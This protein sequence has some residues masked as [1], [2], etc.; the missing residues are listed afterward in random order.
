[1]FKH[2]LEKGGRNMNPSLS[3]AAKRQKPPAKESPASKPIP[4][5]EFAPRKSAGYLLSIVCNK[6]ITHDNSAT[7]KAY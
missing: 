3:S 4:M 5:N 2:A 6:P 7:G 1:M